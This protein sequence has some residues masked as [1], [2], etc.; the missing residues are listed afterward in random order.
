MTTKNLNDKEVKSVSFQNKNSLTDKITKDLD[1]IDI[2]CNIPHIL[3]S[4]YFTVKSSDEFGL[5]FKIVLFKDSILLT[6]ETDTSQLRKDK[7]YTFETVSTFIDFIE[8]EVS[9]TNQELDL[10]IAGLIFPRCQTEIDSQEIPDIQKEYKQ[11]Q[12]KNEEQK[13]NFITEIKNKKEDVA[14]CITKLKNLLKI[15]GEINKIN[16]D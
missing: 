1:F 8:K 10:M 12:I 15:L 4:L 16:N 11:F 5:R 3:L 6:C 13:N 9:Q 2:I 14:S 7:I